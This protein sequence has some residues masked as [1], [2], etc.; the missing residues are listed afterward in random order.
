MRDEQKEFLDVEPGS[1]PKVMCVSAG[2]VRLVPLTAISQG[3][4]RCASRI[5]AY[6]NTRLLSITG[7]GVKRNTANQI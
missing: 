7:Q 5:A 1:Q 6:V 3:A 2:V 4:H